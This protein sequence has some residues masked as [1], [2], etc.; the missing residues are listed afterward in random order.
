M[1]SGCPIRIWEAGI[2][3][4]SHFPANRASTREVNQ[5]DSKREKLD[6]EFQF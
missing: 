4:R 1:L 2:T 6:P 3:I 5:R